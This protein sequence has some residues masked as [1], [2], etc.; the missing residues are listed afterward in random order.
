[1]EKIA[2]LDNQLNWTDNLTATS[3]FSLVQRG[4]FA[5]LDGWCIFSKSIVGEKKFVDYSL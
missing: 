4:Y 1:M 3:R 2:R 5:I